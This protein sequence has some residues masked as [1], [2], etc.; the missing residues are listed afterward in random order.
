MWPFKRKTEIKTILDQHLDGDFSV[1]ACGN[2]APSE[3]V[4]QDFEREI[5]FQLPQDFRAFS[6]SPLGGICVEAKQEI[7]PRAKEYAVGPFWSFLYGVFVFGLARG[8]PEWMDIRIQTTLFRENTK[9]SLVPFLKIVG[10]ANVYCFEQ[11]GSV[12]RWDHELG[13]AQP[14]ALNFGEVFAQ[15]IAELRKRK[16]RKKAE[17]R[18][19]R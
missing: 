18:T 8:I 10:D 12:C 17:G 1:F 7:W 11:H 16:D 14:I 2:D 5:G 9:T 4:L 13:R 15:E 6:I 3:S 19:N